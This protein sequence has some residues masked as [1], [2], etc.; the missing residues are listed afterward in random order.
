M[1]YVTITGVISVGLI[2]STC[3][4]AGPEYLNNIFR[5]EDEASELPT[6]FTPLPEE[7]PT[8]GIFRAS[9]EPFIRDINFG[10]RPRLYF[11]SLEDETGVNNM[12]AGGGA[13]GVTTGWW[14]ETVRFGATGYSAIPLASN[15]DGIDRTGLVEPDG[16]GFGVLGEAWAKLK[17]EQATFT[18]FRQELE[19]PFELVGLDHPAGELDM[20][21]YRHISPFTQIPVLEDGSVV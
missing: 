14:R 16:D 5:P 2:C 12:F 6:P 8:P 21:A 1:N 20:P 10:L 19:L 18:F 15:Q 3:A 11:R 17:I 4:A 7:E 9:K 13:F